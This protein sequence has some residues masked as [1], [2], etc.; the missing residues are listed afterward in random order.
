MSSD[1][2]GGTGRVVASYTGVGNDGRTK[3]RVSARLC[4][5]LGCSLPQGCSPRGFPLCDSAALGMWT[6][7][8][9]KDR[10]DVS[11]WL[12]QPRSRRLPWYYPLQDGMWAEGDGICFPGSPCG[13]VKTLFS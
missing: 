3:V 8:V 1:D 10:E 12:R 13:R 11:Q 9:Y 5:N 7:L 2:L 4:W 6:R